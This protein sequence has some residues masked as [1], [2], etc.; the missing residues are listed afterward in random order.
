MLYSFLKIFIGL[1]FKLFYPLKVEG[2]ENLPYKGAVILVANHSSYFDPLYLGLAIPRRIN[3]MVLRPYYNLWWLKWF[4]KATSCF[5]VNIDKPNIETIKHALVILKQGEVL[6][7][8]PEGGRSE[9]GKLKKAERGVALLA[10]KSGTSILPA[11][12]EG[13]F[14]A[15]PPGAILPKP[16]SI[17]VSFGHLLTFDRL[18]KGCIDEKT[19]RITTEQIMKSIERLMTGQKKN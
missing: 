16:H 13:A 12:I 18:D 3:W 19:L 1:V 8:F 7:I 4:F 9:D 17:N 5:P 10:L 6:G 11:A 15:Y 14:E 2:L